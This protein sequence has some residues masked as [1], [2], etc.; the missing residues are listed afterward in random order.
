MFG[1]NHKTSQPLQELYYGGWLTPNVYELGAAG[2]VRYRGLH[3][4]GWSGIISKGIIFEHLTMNDRL[5][6]RPCPTR[7]SARYFTALIILTVA[8]QRRYGSLFFGLRCRNDATND[9]FGYCLS[10]LAKHPRTEGDIRECHF[11]LKYRHPSKETMNST[12][13][14]SKGLVKS[15]L[16]EVRKEQFQQ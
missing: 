6:S 8:Y 14:S 10:S 5:S 15:L 9:R 16:F 2:V 12:K 13:I 11:A 3:I 7:A 4:G 1:G